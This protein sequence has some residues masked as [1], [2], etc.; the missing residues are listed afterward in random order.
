MH[1][2]SRYLA[3]GAA[4]NSLSGHQANVDVYFAHFMVGK[5]KLIGQNERQIR[6]PNLAKYHI[7]T[8]IESEPL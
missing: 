2:V 5:L 3:G 1:L 6:A 8:E 7:I 4:A